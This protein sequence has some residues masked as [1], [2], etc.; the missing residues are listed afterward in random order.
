MD[1]YATVNAK[2][3]AI[4]QHRIADISYADDRL[5][6]ACGAVMRAAGATDY[7]AHRQ[8]VGEPSKSLTGTIGVRVWHK[9]PA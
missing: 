5:V 4:P 2:R 6:C 3:R 7:P 8:A 9:V 1:Q